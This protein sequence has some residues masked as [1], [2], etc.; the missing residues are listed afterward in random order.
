MAT[1][2]SPI[3][4]RNNRTAGSAAAYAGCI[5]LPDTDGRLQ[6][7][8]GGLRAFCATFNRRFDELAATTRP[9]F[10]SFARAEREMRAAR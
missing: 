1:T 8:D 5:G 2:T 10:R 7:H 9:E 4:R 6:L 3:T